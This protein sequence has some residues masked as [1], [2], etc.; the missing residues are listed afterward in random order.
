MENAAGDIEIEV[1]FEVAAVTV[2]VA[3]ALK[4]PD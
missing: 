4:L 3:C 2:R 1:K